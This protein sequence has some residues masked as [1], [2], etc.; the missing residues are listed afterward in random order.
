MSKLGRSLSTTLI[1]DNVADNYKLQ[2][3]N[4]LNIKNF[5]GDE[6]DSEL[7]ELT[8]DLKRIVIDQVD[9]RHALPRIRDKMMIRYKSPIEGE[10]FTTENDF[11]FIK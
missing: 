4:G 3:L 10:E 8:D 11:S 1:I 9:V 2:D 6:N 7:A 5:E